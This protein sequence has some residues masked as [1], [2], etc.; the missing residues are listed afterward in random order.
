MRYLSIVLS[1]ILSACHSNGNY[2]FT[3]PEAD[4]AAAI[5]RGDTSLV[6]V[7]GYTTMVPGVPG[8]YDSLSR[9]FGVRLIEGTSDSAPK[10]EGSFDARAASYASTYNHVKL[11]RL[12]CDLKNPLGACTHLMAGKPG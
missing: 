3:T 9:I 10:D 11:K 5:A 2:D 8:D 6:G 1:L 12:G 4:A 7:Y